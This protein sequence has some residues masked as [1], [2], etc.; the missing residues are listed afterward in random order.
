MK[1]KL[2]KKIMLG[3]LALAFVGISAIDADAQTFTNTGA[4]VYNA[5]CGAKLRLKSSTTTSPAVQADF[6]STTQGVAGNPIPGIVEWAGSTGTQNVTAHYY[7]LLLLSGSSTKTVAD[8]VHIVP[9]GCATMDENGTTGGDYAYV[10]VDGSG[11][12]TYP[13]DGELFIDGSTTLQPN[14]TNGNHDTY[15]DVVI[16]DGT[17]ATATGVNVAGGVTVITISDA[18][19]DETGVTIAD[20][21]NLTITGTGSELDGNIT[22]GSGTTD[23]TL[24]LESGS[25]LTLSGTGNTNSG[26]INADCGSTI[27]YDGTAAQTIM[28]AAGSTAPGAGQYGNLTLSGSNKTADGNVDVCNTFTLNGAYNLDMQPTVNDHNY[29]LTMLNGQTA[30]PSAV[31]Y[32]STGEVVGQM[33]WN[34]MGTTERTFNNANTRVAITD[35]TGASLTLNSQ[36]GTAP[37]GYAATT[38]V[39]RK[40]SVVSATNV[41]TVDLSI[42]YIQGE[43]PTGFT[44]LNARLFDNGG[45]TLAD[46]IKGSYTTP[47]STNSVIAVDGVTF[48]T[49]DMNYEVGNDLVIRAKEHLDVIAINNGRWTNQN[50]WMDGVL[51]KAGD[52]VYIMANVYAGISGAGNSF[53]GSNPSGTANATNGSNNDYPESTVYSG[54]VF[55]ANNVTIPDAPNGSYYGLVVGNEDNDANFLLK[56]SGIFANENEAL[57]AKNI[58]AFGAKTS[59]TSAFVNG[60]WIVGVEYIG[61]NKGEAGISAKSVTN[62]GTVNN[63]SIIEV[64]E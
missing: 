63:E 36:P 47:T 19:G 34:N 51:P 11:N 6:T 54:N 50:V 15:P 44:Y 27:T 14:P 46:Q 38:D 58:E 41:N 39:N 8:G 49:G 53:L 35:G 3:T 48:G 23:G 62:V 45:T 52:N 61:S 59:N 42:G 22:I 56:F 30:T 57:T 18:N 10:V 20:G 31:T 21:G 40:V 60:L 28:A 37:T 29:T 1:S 16:S 24:T 7:T 17:G 55:A 4:G 43:E 64:G 5:T 2:S 13:A 33:A 12:V 25:D 32:G 26:T 9:T